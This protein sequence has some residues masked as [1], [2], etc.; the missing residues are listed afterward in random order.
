MNIIYRMF[1]YD[2]LYIFADRLIKKYNPCNIQESRSGIATCTCDLDTCCG[3]CKYISIH[4]CTVACLGC[5]LALCRGARY[6]GATELDI[7]VKLWKML[8]IAYSFGHSPVD[9]LIHIRTS[10]GET[11]QR[12]K[13][14]GTD[15]Q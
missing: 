8:S 3:G 6:Q 15:Q 7:S 4:G 2:F 9:G 11:Y 10:R 1:V 14:R 13:S 12:I 5:K